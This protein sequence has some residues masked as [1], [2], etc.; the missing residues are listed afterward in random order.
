MKKKR[1]EIFLGFSLESIPT[2]KSHV[3]YIICKKLAENVYAIRSFLLYYP[4]VLSY[5][6]KL[7]IITLKLWYFFNIQ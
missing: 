5:F 2:W 1:L 4:E 3:D 6:K 7:Y